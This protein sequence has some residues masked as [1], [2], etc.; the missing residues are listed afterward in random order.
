MDPRL[1][2]T[3]V[4]AGLLIALIATCGAGSA[5]ASDSRRPHATVIPG[6]ACARTQADVRVSATATRAVSP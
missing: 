2:R 4:R 1:L 5:N 6:F 3:V